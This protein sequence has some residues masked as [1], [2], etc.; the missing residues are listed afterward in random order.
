MMSMARQNASTNAVIALVLGIVSFLGLPIIAGIPAWILGANELKAID[1]GA[2]PAAG[3][4]MAQIGMI[5]GIVNTIMAVLGILF[6]LFF[7][8][9]MGLIGLHSVSIH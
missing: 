9:G 4:T 6:F 8:G 1:S 5:L 7:M 3:R 2:S